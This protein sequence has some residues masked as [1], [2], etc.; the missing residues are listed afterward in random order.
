M[1]AWWTAQQAGYIG[2]IGGGAVGLIG[3]LVGS[4]SF[5]IVRG[6]AKPFMVGVFAAVIAFG[7]AAL[8]VGIAAIVMK[9]PYH[10]WYPPTLGG[11]IATCLFG[12]LLPVILIRYRQAEARRLEAE[13]LRRG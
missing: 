11:F 10:V 1:E 13:Q 6:K 5:L 3:A 2:A 12:A 8:C 4:M 7:I 9:Q